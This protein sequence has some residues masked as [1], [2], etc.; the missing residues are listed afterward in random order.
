[1]GECKRR[2]AYRLLA[3]F[4][5]CKSVSIYILS[6]LLDSSQRECYRHDAVEL[7]QSESGLSEQSHNFQTKICRREDLE[8]ENNGVVCKRLRK[9][10]WFVLSLLIFC[11]Y[12]EQ[13]ERENLGDELGHCGSRVDDTENS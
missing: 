5:D 1:M 8:N 11:E 6:M 3:S 4:R 2:R 13:R 9:S 7:K 12:L 10:F